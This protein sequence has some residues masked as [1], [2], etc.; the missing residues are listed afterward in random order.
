MDIKECKKCKQTKPLSAFYKHKAMKDG[1]LN[2]CKSCVKERVKKHRWENIDRIRAYDRNRPNHNDRVKQ[3]NERVKALKVIDPEKY[4]KYMETKK[5]WHR[6]NKHKR[7]AHLKVKRAIERGILKRPNRCSSCG[8][9]CKP[10]AHHED[11]S[12]PLDVVWLCRKCH[13]EIHKSINEA[14]RTGAA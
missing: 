3:H 14:K 2:F 9:S 13:A 5:Q 10:E 6:K 11:Y 1:H 8:A 4:K 12:K 7:L